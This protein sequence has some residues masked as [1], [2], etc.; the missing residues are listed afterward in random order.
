MLLETDI[1]KSKRKIND[2]ERNQS[3][4]FKNKFY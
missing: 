1:K 2:S 3:T 4:K